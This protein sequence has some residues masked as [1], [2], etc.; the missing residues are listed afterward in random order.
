MGQI[1]FLVSP[2][3]RVTDEILQL[4][5]MAGLDRTPWQVRVHLE[6]QV[7]V[8][9]RDTSESGTLTVPWR[10]EGHGLMGLST[11]TLVERAKPYLLPLELARGAIN[12]LRGHL[13]EWQGIGLTVPP[14]VT[15]KL[16]EAIVQFSGAA[17][18]QDSPW[19]PPQARNAIRLA[20]DASQILAAAYAEQAMVVRRRPTGKVS[21]LMGGELSGGP[22]ENPLAAQFLAAF[23]AALVPLPW[24]DVEAAEARFDW[25][26]IDQQIEWCRTQGLA[27]C[28]GPLLQLDVRWLPDWAYLW[29]DDFDNL[30]AAAGEFVEAAVNRY[31]GKIDFWHCAA[32]VNTPELLALPE[33]DNL[34]LTASILGLVSRLDPDTPRTISIDQ[35]WGEYMGRREVDFP[36]LHFA[37]A[38]VRARLDLKAIILE[39]NLGSFPGST[40]PRSELELN[41][42]LDYWSL[43]GLPLVASLCI[44]SSTVED[45]LA[46]RKAKAPLGSWSLELQQAWAARYVPLLLAKPCVAGVFWNQLRDATPHDFPHAGLVADMRQPK[47]AFRA[48]AGI[49]TNCLGPAKPPGNG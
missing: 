48:L 8:V 45:P 30:L 21:L 33:E 19:S 37:D 47:P 29:E 46:R 38:L 7:L 18:S 17:V 49:R 44:P 27:V 40:L 10:V 32:R 9:E 1:R 16:H 2:P 28:A 25:S 42:L 23:N 12:Q 31:K 39:L 22:L 4:A 35:P 24:R 36:P 14:A 20:L 43:L 5:Y 11:G 41:R 3:D 13:F 6:D 26:T 34:R 15:E